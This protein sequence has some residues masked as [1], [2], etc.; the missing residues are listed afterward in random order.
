M[1]KIEIND[2][3]SGMI[4]ER[5]VMDNK[6]RV[7]LNEGSELK[8]LHISKLAK[9]GT[10]LVYVKDQ[11]SVEKNR[12]SQPGEAVDGEGEGHEANTEIIRRDI[13]DKVEK[14]FS[15]VKDDELMKRLKD[16][17]IRNQIKAKL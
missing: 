14:V 11:D 13:T 16:L 3:K 9:W 15:R 12:I 6:G 17:A 5:S 1:P 10:E 4:L 7:I 2:A 8:P